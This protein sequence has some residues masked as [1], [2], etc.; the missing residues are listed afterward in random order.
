LSEV[1]ARHFAGQ[2]VQ[3][4]QVTCVPEPSPLGTAGGFLHAASAAS[5][6]PEAWLVMNGDSLAVSDLSEAVS[7]L[8]RPSVE[9]VLVGLQMADAFRYGTLRV[10]GRSRLV[11][12]EEKRPGRGVINAGVYFLR[13][14][15]LARFPGRR[16]LS[17]EQDVFPA[18]VKAGREIDVSVTHAPFLD[19]GTPESLAQ[20][21]DF[22]QAN[23]AQL[24]A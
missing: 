15:L 2:P 1:V 17:F 18:W 13:H 22:V 7:L 20:A 10:D 9:G 16:P 6:P 4:M 12:F 23:H 14:D 19:I 5:E 24:G 11:A 8:A 21:E 3:G